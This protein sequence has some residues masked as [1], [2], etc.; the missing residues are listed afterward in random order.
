M[1]VYLAGPMRGHRLFNFP[2]FFSAALALRGVGHECV[3]P[4]E[5]DM[6][7]G[8][9]P[10]QTETDQDF[11]LEAAFTF[12]FQAIMRAGGVVL[13]PGWETSQGVAAELVVAKFTGTQVY[14]YDPSCPDLIRPIDLDWPV[15]GWRSQDEKFPEL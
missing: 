13:L 8:I 11:D 9:D 7:Q 6:A 10:S 4:A 2:A 12:D 5:R 1:L 3:N 14:E 15:I